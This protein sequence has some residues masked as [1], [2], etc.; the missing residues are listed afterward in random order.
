MVSI[1]MCIYYKLGIEFGTYMRLKLIENGQHYQHRPTILLKNISPALLSRNIV[2][3]CFSSVVLF[4]PLYDTTDGWSYRLSAVV[5]CVVTSR[6]VYKGLVVRDP[7]DV[8]TQN[9]SLSGSPTEL[10]L[11]P[12]QLAL[13]YVWLSLT[14]FASVES[15][16]IASAVFSDNIVAPLVG[17]RW[18]RHL[19]SVPLSK[20]KTMEGSV[21]GV[22]LGT[23]VGCYFYMYIYMYIFNYQTTND[24]T[25]IQ[26]LLPLRMILTY[27]AIAAVAEGTAPSNLDNL[28]ITAMIHFSIDPVQKL[29]PP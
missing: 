24:G 20:T 1:L 4:W 23:V 2:Q 3:G 17:I 18:G 22:F 26:P 9:I 19:Y 13:I 29:L 25:T 14:G 10:L 21:V 28:V 6:L 5:P 15:I 16:I 11:G 7:T 12:T 8:E 27:A